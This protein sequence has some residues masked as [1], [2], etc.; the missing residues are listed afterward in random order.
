MQGLADGMIRVLHDQRIQ[1]QS[2][3]THM[4]APAIEPVQD[5][6]IAITAMG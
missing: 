6:P 5:E 1:A 2:M 4:H 3:E